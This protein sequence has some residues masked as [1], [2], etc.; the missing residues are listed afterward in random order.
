MPKEEK[1][2]AE[3]LPAEVSAEEIA[4]FRKK[5]NLRVRHIQ[6]VQNVSLLLADRLAE[7]GEFDLARRLVQRSLRHDSSK[8]EGI[9]W[10]YLDIASN[11]KVNR[12]KLRLAINQHQQSNDHHPEY[13]SGG[14]SDMS[15]V[16]LAEMVCDWKARSEEF[17]SSLV[18]WVKEVACER[19][20]FTVR[21]KV[22][23]K[24]KF[25][26]DLLLDPKIG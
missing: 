6:N 1:N 18:D 2:T 17:G 22:Y 14:V 4:A 7:K 11:D 3:D 5:L 23:Q 13:F 25:F 24:I 9:E 16:Q 15:S 21:S 10:E 26:L 12:S 20:G 8:F 19:Y